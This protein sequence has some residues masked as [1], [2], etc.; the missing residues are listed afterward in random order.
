MLSVGAISTLEGLAARHGKFYE[1]L[2]ATLDIQVQE[3][4]SSWVDADKA[5]AIESSLLNLETIKQNLRLQNVSDLAGAVFPEATTPATGGGKRPAERGV[6]EG[7]KSKPAPNHNPH[8]SLAL[9][10]YAKYDKVPRFTYEIPKV[11][12]VD[13][14]G[15]YHC[16]QICNTRC[17]NVHGRLSAEVLAATG[18][19]VVESKS[20][21]AR[22]V[23]GRDE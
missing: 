15:R 17:K 11:S 21:T 9:T 3:Y 13:V 2:L 7:V 5:E 19:W 14:W 22:G 16:R 20:K 18:A 4:F 8:Q 23:P 6:A 1:R 12:C 10:S